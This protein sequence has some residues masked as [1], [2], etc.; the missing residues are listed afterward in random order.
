MSNK[1]SSISQPSNPRRLDNSSS[2]SSGNTNSADESEE[3]YLPFE[4][5]SGEL[6]PEEIIGILIKKS[7]VVYFSSDY[8]FFSKELPQGSSLPDNFSDFHNI[9]NVELNGVTLKREMM[10]DVQ[11]HTVDDP[12]KGLTF[13][14]CKADE[15][16]REMI[17]NIIGKHPSVSY[18]TI[19]QTDMTGKK[20]EDLLSTICSRQMDCLKILLGEITSDA[21]G[22]L[23]NS[24]KTSEKSLKELMIG[25]VHIQQ[26]VLS[27]IA[28]VLP[29]LKSLQ[30]LELSFPSLLIND[31]RAV[32][33][34]IG[35]LKKLR[36]LKIFI[37]EWVPEDAKSKNVEQFESAEILKESLSKLPNLELLDISHMNLPTEIMQS[38]ATGIGYIS[39]LRTLNLTGNVI[40]EK[41]AAS[42]KEA[43]EK[44]NGFLTTLIANNCAMTDESFGI[45]AQSLP[46]I[47]LEYLYVRNNQIKSPKRFPVDSMPQIIL[48]DLY[49]NSI[50]LD[51]AMEF[52]K[53]IPADSALRAVNL[54]GNPS[55]HAPN[56][57]LIMMYNELEMEK[58]KKQL[59]TLFYF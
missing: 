45:F 18:I 30:E 31:I 10:E 53:L 26:G 14:S 51:E 15:E 1:T 36:K 58:Q 54:K 38:I 28:K 37:G 33:G 40:D 6:K 27:E 49:G 3:S 35:K 21:G 57:Q 50:S 16:G 23:Q 42:F 29:N 34:A 7:K 8:R 44:S 25:S 41:V 12:L 9:A 24:L 19:M 17:V 13:R 48:I 55:E 5:S 47:P 39:N 43:F 59:K 56:S 20:A 2:S 22:F 52:I 4:K 32:F 46:K 11:K